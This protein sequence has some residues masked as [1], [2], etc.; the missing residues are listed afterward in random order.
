MLLALV[1]SIIIQL[2]TALIAIRIGKKINRN[3][4]W[5]LI[6]IAFVLM[7]MGRIVTVFSQTLDDYFRLDIFNAFLT[8]V[9][10]IVFLFSLK[11]ISQLLNAQKKLEQAERLYSLKILKSNI[12]AE[13]HIKNKFSQELHDGL[14]PLLS[15]AQMTLST[16]KNPNPANNEKLDLCNNFINESIQTLREVS[17]GLSPRILMDFGIEKAIK[18]FCYKLPSQN[19]PEISLY[20]NL[21]SKRYSFELEITIYRMICE[22]INNTCKHAQ[23]SQLKISITKLEQTIFI[24]CLDNGI[25]I[26]SEASNEA[27]GQGFLNLKSRIQLLNGVGQLKTIKGR[28]TYLNVKFT[29][30]D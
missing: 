29:I 28:G 27:Q 7:V 16:I 30:Q 5:Y 6:S 25:G 26:N 19:L 22:A 2:I 13:E 11:G 24:K 15:I 21:G 1:S 23:A 10:S 20:S 8:L 12:N 4:S 17:N 14:G 9:T 18:T 3:Q